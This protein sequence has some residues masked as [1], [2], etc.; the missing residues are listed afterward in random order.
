MQKINK[1]YSLIYISGDVDLLGDPDSLGRF[2]YSLRSAVCF[3][4]MHSLPK[5]ADRGSADA[6]VDA[7]TRVINKDTGSFDVRRQYFQRLIKIFR[8]QP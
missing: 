7:V 2:P 1:Q 5:I 4:T 8:K 3:W 6:T